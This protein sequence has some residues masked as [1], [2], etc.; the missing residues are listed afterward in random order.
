MYSVLYVF[1]FASS[2]MLIS[3]GHMDSIFEWKYIDYLWI[4]EVVRQE[5]VQNGTYD[6]SRILP[7]DVEKSRGKLKLKLILTYIIII[8]MYI[9]IFF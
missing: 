6:F 9:Y 1:I 3:A 2:L 8:C 7:M 4:S 5:A